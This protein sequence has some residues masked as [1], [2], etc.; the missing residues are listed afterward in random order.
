VLTRAHLLPTASL[1]S[2]A[3]RVETDVL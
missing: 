2:I 3:P 1:D